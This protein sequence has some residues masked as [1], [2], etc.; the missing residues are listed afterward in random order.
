MLYECLIGLMPIFDW[1][2]PGVSRTKSQI[3]N[4]YIHTKVNTVE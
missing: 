4:I 2:V 3:H 1:R